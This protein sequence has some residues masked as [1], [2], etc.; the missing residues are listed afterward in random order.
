M[1][2]GVSS[3]CF[4]PSETR[5]A[6]ER[7]GKL[8]A[9]CTEVFF[10][11]V[12]ELDLKYVK[13]IRN[14]ADYHG[15]KIASV[16][17]FTSFA[18]SFFLFSNYE[19]RFPDTLDFYKRYFEA[20]ETLGAEV[21][22]LH[23]ARPKKAAPDEQCFERIGK[24][25]EEGKRFGVKIAQ[26]NVVDFCSQSVDYLRRMRGFLKED[27]NMVLDLKQAKL[28]GLNAFSLL[29]EFGEN[30][31]HLHLSDQ[32]GEQSCL[33]PGEGDFDFGKMFNILQKGN[34]VGSA[35]I[36]LYSQNYKRDEQIRN[37][38]DF[39]AKLC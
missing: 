3:A 28:S 16:H 30:I 35:V 31:V 34:Y 23:G 9:R 14:I 13:E 4:Y 7:V 17:P 18:E 5:T 10:N 26:E 25:A 27:F 20:A 6:L 8:G 12:S 2:I 1:D 22:V 38:M 32:N 21:F 33:P 37:S 36:E 11:S 39:L 19:S 24:M 29:D 15:I